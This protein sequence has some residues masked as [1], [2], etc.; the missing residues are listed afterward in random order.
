MGEEIMAKIMEV[1]CCA[2]CLHSEEAVVSPHEGEYWCSLLRKWVSG[3][4]IDPDCKLDD[5]P[6][7]E[8]VRL[9]E[10]V[11]SWKYDNLIRYDSEDGYT[12]R[13]DIK[14][15]ENYITSGSDD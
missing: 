14:R 8:L 15:L 12:F 1:N 9:V 11:I 5:N 10:E 7:S 3:G 6:A 4:G 2:D 13:D